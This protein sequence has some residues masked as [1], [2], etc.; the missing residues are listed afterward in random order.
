MRIATARRG[1]FIDNEKRKI[2]R[3]RSLVAASTANGGCA[4]K[5]VALVP[6]EPVNHRGRKN[7]GKWPAGDSDVVA[8]VVGVGAARRILDVDHAAGAERLRVR[9]LALPGIFDMAAL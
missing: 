3:L 1:K 6:G 5:I 9:H 7:R 2:A 8:V 4:M